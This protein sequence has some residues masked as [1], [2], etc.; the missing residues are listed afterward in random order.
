MSKT[1]ENIRKYLVLMKEKELKEVLAEVPLP[2]LIEQWDSL[3]EEEG[4][5]IFTGLTK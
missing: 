4:V 5:R 1:M 3:S 2:E